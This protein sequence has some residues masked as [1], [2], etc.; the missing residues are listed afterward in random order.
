RCTGAEVAPL[1]GTSRPFLPAFPFKRS[2]AAGDPVLLALPPVFCRYLERLFEDFVDCDA[3]ELL[4]VRA[5][6]RIPR[7]G[8]VSL[9]LLARSQGVELRCVEPPVLAGFVECDGF[10]EEL[11]AVRDKLLE[12]DA[13][14]DDRP[15][16]AV[17][18]LVGQVLILVR[19]ASEATLPWLR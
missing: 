13:D 9:A 5:D 8:D 15:P 19:G 7:I 12:V 2:Q 6:H 16:P 17:T 3:V 10:A 11:V 1:T 14:A 4:E 18:G